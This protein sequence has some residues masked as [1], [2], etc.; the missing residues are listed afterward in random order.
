MDWQQPMALAIVAAT[1]GILAWRQFRPRRSSFAKATHCGCDMKAPANPPQ[2][3]VR[4]RRGER[5]QIIY[6]EH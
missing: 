3:I 1:A 2:I 5:Q 6:R 4:S